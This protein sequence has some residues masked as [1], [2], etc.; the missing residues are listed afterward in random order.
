MQKI[1]A[2]ILPGGEGL[3]RT[4]RL[5]KAGLMT[6]PSDIEAKEIIASVSI[7]QADNYDAA[8]AISLAYPGDG[9]IDIREMCGYA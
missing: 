5:V 4:C 3:E 7:I 9:T 2:S 1:S 6:D 8:L